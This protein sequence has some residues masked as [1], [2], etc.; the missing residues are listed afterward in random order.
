MN[1][2]AFHILITLGTTILIIAFCLRLYLNFVK[3][4]QT[5][6]PF[7]KGDKV[8]AFGNIGEVKSVGPNGYLTVKFDDFESTV[9][10]HTDGKLMKWNK[11][12]SLTKI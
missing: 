12:V 6:T 2:Q 4:K 1:A 11:N 7:Q 9:V 10:F 8:T 5:I 3:L